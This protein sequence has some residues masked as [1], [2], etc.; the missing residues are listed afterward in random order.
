[1]GDGEGPVAEVGVGGCE[2]RLG[3]PPRRGLPALSFAS[4]ARGPDGGCIAAG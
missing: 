2:L 4:K 3:T 1:M